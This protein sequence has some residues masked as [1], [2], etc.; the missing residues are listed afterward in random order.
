MVKPLFFLIHLFVYFRKMPKTRGSV[1]IKEDPDAVPRKIAKKPKGS[2]I[3]E[4]LYFGPNLQKKVPNLFP[5]HYPHKEKMVR[6]VIWQLFF[7]D[8]SQSE[9]LSEIK[10]PLKIK[11]TM[12]TGKKLLNY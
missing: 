11:Q 12:L 3:S 10:P 5:E 9:K 1:Q 7:G 4:V 8:L 2:L 6:V